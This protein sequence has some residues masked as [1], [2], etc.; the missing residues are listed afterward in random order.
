[1]ETRSGDFLK[2][3]PSSILCESNEPNVK[4][5]QT[6]NKYKS[7]ARSHK[8]QKNK[9]KKTRT[10]AFNSSQSYNKMEERVAIAA[11]YDSPSLNPLQ[12]RKA[13]SPNIFAT[14]PATTKVNANI[15][16]YRAVGHAS[17]LKQPAKTDLSSPLIWQV[18]QLNNN[19]A[20][21]KNA[22]LLKDTMKESEPIKS[23]C[24]RKSKERKTKARNKSKRTQIQNEI[25]LET[26]DE[27]FMLI[28][29]DVLELITEES[30]GE[31]LRNNEP[32]DALI[33][34]LLPNEYRMK[35]ID[36]VNQRMRILPTNP[37]KKEPESGTLTRKCYSLGL[38][39]H[40]A[41][42]NP[43]LLKLHQTHN[44]KETSNHEEKCIPQISSQPIHPSSSN[45]LTHNS[46]RQ[47]DGK[48]EQAELASELVE[49]TRLLSK[50]NT[51]QATSFW[52]EQV[53]SLKD[54][55][56]KLE[57][58][59]SKHNVPESELP[60]GRN[61]EKHSNT[62]KE[63][64]DFEK[65]QDIPF[66]YIMLKEDDSVTVGKNNLSPKHDNQKKYISDPSPQSIL[67][68]L[69]NLTN[70]KS[71]FTKAYQHQVK[72]DLPM[73]KVVAPSDLPGGYSFEAYVGNSKFLAMVVSLCFI[74]E[75]ILYHF[76]FF[77]S[78]TLLKTFEIMF[79]LFIHFLN[80]QH[81][82]SRRNKERTGILNSHGHIRHNTNKCHDRN[83]ER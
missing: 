55:I 74:I 59:Q 66:D 71:E 78:F 48:Q 49:A 61:I 68:S 67:K 10:K 44:E 23:Q 63:N 38:G 17:N 46:H 77:V 56:R 19:S 79:W 24:K 75:H 40:D 83:M 57:L 29:S 37:D 39:S 64:G 28:A 65:K 33:E 81:L 9:L 12:T 14:K 82:A 8:E 80:D 6:A 25:N 43:L 62:C 15:P 72:K 60:D 2:L 54:R 35:F 31:N 26:D 4:K 3:V 16:L 36:A 27:A 45:G 1:M 50:S 76:H 30:D 20:I 53:I 34:Q 7:Q 52:K 58:E 11:A 18:K 47:I 73:V 32:K 22:K 41:G 42:T 13:L 69:S 5:A 21:E 70:G 51:E